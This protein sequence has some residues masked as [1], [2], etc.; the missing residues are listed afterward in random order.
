MIMEINSTLVISEIFTKKADAYYT[1]KLEEI[2][3]KI[4]QF[5]N[6]TAKST[7][8]QLKEIA[9][10]VYA[11]LWRW[12][13]IKI[14]RDGIRPEHEYLDY[15][16]DAASSLIGNGF[17]FSLSSPISK[18]LVVR[19]TIPYTGGQNALQYSVKYNK[20]SFK[21]RVFV[22]SIDLY[23]F[24]QKRLEEVASDVKVERDRFIDL[25]EQNQI[26][27]DEYMQSREQQFEARITLQVN[28][29][30]EEAVNKAKGNDL[31]K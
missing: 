29:L 11:N 26:E 7:P 13:S 23:F 16:I 24:F 9:S 15:S 2:P 5:G 28:Q 17:T 21:G 27:V 20:R 22:N 10:K 19:Y 18:L 4:N 30:F 6:I 3:S 25:I 12:P 14:N 1:E 8:E 31:L